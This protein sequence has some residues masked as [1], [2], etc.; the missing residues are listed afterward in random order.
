MFT[1]WPFF[2][3]PFVFLFFF[4]FG[5][6]TE[7]KLRNRRRTQAIW[8]TG[9]LH[10]HLKGRKDEWETSSLVSVAVVEVPWHGAT[11]GRKGSF[12]L[13]VPGHSPSQQ[14]SQGVRNPQQS[15]HHSHSGE[16]RERIRGRSACLLS[17]FS[18]KS[19]TK[20]RGWDGPLLG[21]GPSCIN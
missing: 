19:G 7:R 6:F 10:P 9:M 15:G 1:V 8:E 3:P 17:P 11:Q 13:P 5:V 20:P 12:S 14:R 2:L 16:Q 4:L 21:G 18:Y